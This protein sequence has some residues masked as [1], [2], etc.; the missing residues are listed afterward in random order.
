MQRARAMG[1]VRPLCVDSR[2]SGHRGCSVA[3]AVSCLVVV[4][5]TRGRS[6]AVAGKGGAG[7]GRRVTGPH[8]PRV[9]T[10]E[11]WRRRQNG[12]I[13]LIAVGVCGAMVL[14]ATNA[15]FTA[16]TTNG[17]NSFGAG[18]VALSDDDS[19]NALFNLSGLKPGDS[20]NQC[21]TVSYT[22]SL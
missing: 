18:T 6:S 10:G 12:L 22:G 7:V 14:S 11:W 4:L 9:R 2:L 1:L 5:P 16:T 17:A 19:G 13:A 20:M 8:P 21:I 3:R 15:A